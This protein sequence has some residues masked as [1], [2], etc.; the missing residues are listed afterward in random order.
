LVENGAEFPDL[1][2]KEY[3]DGLRGV[4]TKTGIE[5]KQP[6]LRIPL[7]CMIMNDIAAETEYGRIAVEEKSFSIN[8]KLAIFILEEM[9]SGR[10]FFQPYLDMLP[11]KY[12]SF[13]LRWT[14][15]ELEWIKG[16][17]AYTQTLSRRKHTKR[18]YD[19]ACELLPGFSRFPF[20]LFF[21]AKL[22]VSSR[23]FGVEVNGRVYSAMVPFA[24]MLNHYQPADVNW[25]YNNQLQCFEF[26][27]SHP[28]RAGQQVSMLFPVFLSHR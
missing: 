20:S 3:D 4:C 6:I 9:E 21:W 15:Q 18:E 25:D 27:S 10:S 11:R 26:K 24:D 19:R 23:T 12:N 28:L 7:K 22:A 5:S 2:V 8:C 13:P 17:K 1:F 14:E 16:S